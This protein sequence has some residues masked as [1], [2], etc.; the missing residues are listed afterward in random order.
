[1]WSKIIFSIRNIVCR[2]NSIPSEDDSVFLRDEI[3]E[4]NLPASREATAK[5]KTI[6]SSIKGWFQTFKHFNPPTLAKSVNIPSAKYGVP[7]IISTGGCG[8]KS[9]FI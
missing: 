7:Y 8:G 1:M 6:I 3:N 9:L 5:E 4:N 2:S